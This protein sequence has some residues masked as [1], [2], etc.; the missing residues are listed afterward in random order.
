M[1]KT[2]T[3]LLVYL[4]VVLVSSPSIDMIGSSK[5]RPSYGRKTLVLNHTNIRM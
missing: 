5:I 4:L 1:G 2:L 3:S